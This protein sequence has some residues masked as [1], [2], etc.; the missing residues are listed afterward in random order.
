MNWVKKRNFLAI[1]DIQFN[2]KPYIK[3]DDLW[4]ALYKL[5]N[6]AQNY[7][8]DISLLEEILDKTTMI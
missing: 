3:L 6:A 2:S 7:Q 8:V 5:F 4:E 1:K